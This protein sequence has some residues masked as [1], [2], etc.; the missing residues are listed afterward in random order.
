MDKLLDATHE[1][2]QTHFWFR[3]F[4]MF[5][6]PLLERAAGG[7]SALR[8]LD[9]GCGTGN[10]LS[11]VGEFGRAYGFDL[12][13]RGLG[14]ARAAGHPRIAQAT[15]LAIPF[16]DGAFDLV[17][18][19]DVLACLSAADG[20]N[21]LREI[22]RVLK[23]GGALVLNTAALKILHGNHSVVAAE[24]HRYTRRELKQSIERAGFRI[25]RLSYTNAALMPIVLPVRV[26]QRLAGLATP[27][28]AGTD[29]AIP[30]G[31]INSLLSGTLALEARVLRRIDMPIG[32]SL[33]CL[34]W[35]R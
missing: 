13:W 10:N 6:R 20:V 1:A 19:F 5:I 9:A 30:P 31:F 27:E 3:G 29:F 11:M 4:Q 8:V 12:T 24:L 32:S 21:A 17:T 14:Y 25:E 26:A 7:R 34:A 15:I 16:A 2:E 18:S 28:E 33:L 22:H 35:K 23:P